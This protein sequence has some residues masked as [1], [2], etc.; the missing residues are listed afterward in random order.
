MTHMVEKQVFIA[1]EQA[2]RMKKLSNTL[3]VSGGG[4][5]S[6]GDAAPT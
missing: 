5:D 2:K 1:P 4:V 3:G 6:E